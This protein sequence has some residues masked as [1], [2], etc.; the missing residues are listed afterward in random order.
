MV[1]AVAALVYKYPF[2]FLNVIIWTLKK[3]IKIG[4]WLIL[5]GDNK[6]YPFKRNAYIH[7]IV[8][9]KLRN[10]LALFSFQCKLTQML[11]L[12]IILFCSFVWLNCFRCLGYLKNVWFNFS[13][14]KGC[15]LRSLCADTQICW[16]VNFGSGEYK[17]KLGD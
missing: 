1:C 10:L 15:H 2:R 16:P 9:G 14:K 13:H 11:S 3:C 17:Y 7:E 6:Q 4:T 12:I 8:G 5:A